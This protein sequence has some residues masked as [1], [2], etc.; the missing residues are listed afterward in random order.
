MHIRSSIAVILICGFAT[1]SPAQAPQ[2]PPKP[3]PEHKALE[4][5]VG[6]WA[7][8]ANVKANKFVGAGKTTMTEACTLGTGGFYVVCRGE[9]G[10]LPTRLA[11]IGYDSQAKVYTSFYANSGGLVGV[12]TGS[13]DGDTWTWMVDDK[14]AGR[15]V[16]GRTTLTVSSPTQYTSRYEMAD[17]NGGYTTIVEAKA[18]RVAPKQ[19]KTGHELS[20]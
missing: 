17:E 9:G 20:R 8:E 13:I 4:Y 15:S 7:V 1:L 18:R 16:K 14:F 2:Q 19:R 12:A 10:E 3:G 11:I 5:L 6:T